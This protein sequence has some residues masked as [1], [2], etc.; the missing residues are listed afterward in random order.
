MPRLDSPRIERSVARCRLV[1]SIAA[2]AAVFIDPTQPVL[3]RWFPLTGGSFTINPYAL[4]VM[5]TYLCY[6][7]IIIAVVDREPFSLGR[8]SLFTTWADVAFGTAV[9]AFTE[10][11]TSPF[12]AFFAFAVVEAGLTAGFRRALV[13]T[14]VSVGL[15]LSLIVISSPGTVESYIMRP[16]YLAIAG[17][18]VGYLGQERLNLERGI[19]ELAAASQRMRI[20]R[21]LHDGRA[22][23]FAGIS[24]QLES[25]QE[26]LR[27]G[28]HTEALADLSDLQ[29][30]VNRE[31]DELRAYMRSLVG[32]E[33]APHLKKETSE[34]RFSL[35]A[36]FDCSAE[37]VDQVLQIL[38]EG[39]TNVIRHAGARTAEIQVRQL[40]TRIH[41]TIDD[42]GVGFRA[43]GQEPWSIASRVRELGGFLEVVRNGGPGAH[44]AITLPQISA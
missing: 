41:I 39:V 6:S 24:L 32:L 36:R 1:L 29:A 8:F 14:A 20:A 26:L 16:A 42:D 3:T 44:L 28:R 31:Y 9:A 17:Y 37:V 30:S 4:A 19:E 18:L 10:G 5:G 35:V 40:G 23:A 12:H 34:T 15:Y 7:L 27:R 21:D 43:P 25:C 22:Q 13:V 38:R 11:I 2:L 33:T